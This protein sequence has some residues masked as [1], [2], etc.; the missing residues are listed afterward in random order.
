MMHAA[1][2]YK[3]TKIEETPLAIVHIESEYYEE[4]PEILREGP[5]RWLENMDSPQQHP[6][7]KRQTDQ[8]RHMDFLFQLGQRYQSAS[9]EEKS[10]GSH[11]N[12][13]SVGAHRAASSRHLGTSG[14]DLIKESA[15]PQPAQKNAAETYLGISL[16]DISNKLFNAS[17][18]HTSYKVKTEGVE[19]TKEEDEDLKRNRTPL[20]GFD[21]GK[22]IPR[23][24][25][26][27][28]PAMPFMGGAR[29]SE[30]APLNDPANGKAPLFTEEMRQRQEQSL[31]PVD[32]IRIMNYQCGNCNE[33]VITVDDYGGYLQPAPSEDMSCV[34]IPNMNPE[35]L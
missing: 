20:A 31:A 29:A 25:F 3:K 21:I 5:P 27:S 12:G 6:D 17:I 35:E 15:D 8:R 16:R 1:K 33:K 34:T 7:A 18:N 14:S 19:E 2:V 22:V 9:G 10:A 11:T 23:N 26:D 30:E 24:F 13:G 4:K 32:E 28:I